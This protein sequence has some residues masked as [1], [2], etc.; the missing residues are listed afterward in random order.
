VRRLLL[1]AA[2]ALGL[3]A[4]GGSSQA[5]KPMRVEFGT[6][7]GNIRPRTFAITVSGS[8]A[9]QLRKLGTPGG[10]L[11]C[12]GTLPDVAAIY[13]RVEGRMV[14]TVHGSCYPSFTRVWKKLYALRGSSG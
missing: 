10:V 1:I 11:S 14:M 12:K 6:K 13:I 7:G 3:A 8:P 9:N 4:C 5:A 2:I